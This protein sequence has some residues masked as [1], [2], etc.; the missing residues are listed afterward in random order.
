VAATKQSFRKLLS[1]PLLH[2]L[3]LGGLLFGL[4]EFLGRDDGGGKDNVIAV[5]SDSLAEFLALRSKTLGSSAA[6]QQFE[7]L[8]ENE[9]SKLVHDFVRQEALY[10]EAKSMGLDEKDVGVRR[11]LIGQVEF[12]NQGVV[13]ASISLSDSELREFLDQNEQRYIEPAAVTFTHVFFNTERRGDKD[14]LEQADETLGLLNGGGDSQPIPFHKA[15][16]YG[17]RFLYAQNYVDDVAEEIASHF[18][19]EMQRELFALTPNPNVW[20]GPFR[21]EYGFHLVLVTKRTES[22]LPEF[23]RLRKRLEQDLFQQ[24]LKQ[25]LQ[26]LE[27]GVIKNYR[28]TID[29]GLRERLGTNPAN[30][31]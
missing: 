13:G 7:Q 10:R 12:I 2:F 1:E 15:P 28:I 11:R 19:G 27:S 4:Y 22:Y 21:S 25:E 23:D 18:G 24:R 31:P 17:D 6:Q 8:S 5:S 16:A 26:S 9:L 3:A 20:R 29:D 14:A 30:Q